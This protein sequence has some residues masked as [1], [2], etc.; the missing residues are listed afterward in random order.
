MD[1]D[2][3]ARPFR[4]NSVHLWQELRLTMSA[5]PTGI[6]DSRDG[7]EKASLNRYRCAVPGNSGS[8]R[9]RAFAQTLSAY[10][11]FC[12]PNFSSS[13]S[14]IFFGAGGVGAARL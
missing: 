14:I 1:L 11:A 8:A 3:F 13:V 4:H 10:S 2:C 6:A 9:W 5:K 7:D 12:G